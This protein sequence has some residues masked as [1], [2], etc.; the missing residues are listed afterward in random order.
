MTYLHSLT[1][2]ELIALVRTQLDLVTSELERELAKR[3]ADA[4]DM[5]DLRTLE[6]KEEVSDLEFQLE[7]A[8]AAIR[9]LEERISELEPEVVEG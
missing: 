9:K 6:L 5:K 1:D 4:V 8:E 3:L 2:E 7:T